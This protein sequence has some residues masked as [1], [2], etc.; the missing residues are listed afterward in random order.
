MSAAEKLCERAQRYN[1]GA[2]PAQ[3]YARQSK[4][5]II[6]PDDTCGVDTLKKD[7]KSLQQLYDKGYSDDKKITGLPEH[8]EVRPRQR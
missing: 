5:L 2:A 4:V 3:E 8:R 7:K 1:G 6:A